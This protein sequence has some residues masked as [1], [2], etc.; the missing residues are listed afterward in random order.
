MHGFLR[1]CANFASRPRF[2][3]PY[4]VSCLPLLLVPASAPSP[5][6]TFSSFLL[7]LSDSFTSSSGV[8]SSPLATA[9][10]ILLQQVP[11]KAL[12]GPTCPTFRPTTTSIASTGYRPS[13]PLPIGATLPGEGITMFLTHAFPLFCFPSRMHDFRRVFFHEPNLQ[14]VLRTNSL[15]AHISGRAST[16]PCGRREYRH[17]EKS[18][19]PLGRLSSGS[20]GVRRC[21]SE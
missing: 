4:P 12:C 21:L 13:W 2:A 3:L 19:S 7:A 8:A 16:R 5:L 10:S 1:Y 18:P 17:G 9:A 11:M 20:S 6:A 14:L 15:F